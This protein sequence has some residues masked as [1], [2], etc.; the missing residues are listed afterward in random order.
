MRIVPE[1]DGEEEA[2]LGDFIGDLDEV[3]FSRNE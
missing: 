1:M 3:N 2:W